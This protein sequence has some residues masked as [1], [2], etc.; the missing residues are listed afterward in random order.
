MVNMAVLAVSRMWR[1]F[2]ALIVIEPSL[3]LLMLEQRHGGVSELCCKIQVA[4]DG[5]PFQLANFG[6]MSP[7]VNSLC[8]KNSESSFMATKP[9]VLVLRPSHELS[10]M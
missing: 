1:R 2:A 8:P 4:G 6:R 5:V 10:K 7:D 3:T 9:H